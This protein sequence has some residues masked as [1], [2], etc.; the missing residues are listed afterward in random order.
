MLYTTQQ[1]YFPKR[2]QDF[3]LGMSLDEFKQR[4]DISHMEIDENDYISYITEDVEDKYVLQYTYQFDKEKILYEMMIQYKNSVD[5]H[6]LMIAMYG[7][8]NNG[9]E[10][11]IDTGN[12][13]LKVWRF[14]KSLC[15]ADAKYFEF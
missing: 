4:K 12:I 1:K 7:E 15:I 10:W 8:P 13:T 11:M 14:G 5:V 2:L 6:Q 9:D 3:N